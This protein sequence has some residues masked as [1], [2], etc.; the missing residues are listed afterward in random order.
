MSRLRPHRLKVRQAVVVLL[1]VLGLHAGATGEDKIAQELSISDLFKAAQFDRWAGE[2]SHQDIIW[3]TRTLIHGLSVHQRMVAHLE[4]DIPVSE[5]LKRAADETLLMLLQV[6]D[7]HGLRYRDYGLIDLKQNRQESHK[8][9]SESTWEAFALP[10]DY[11][12]SFLLY[13]KASGEHSFAQHTLHVAAVKHDDFEEIWQGTPKW[14]FWGALTEL[15][16]NIYRPDIHSRLHLVLATKNP[17]RVD[18]LADLTPSDLFH[19]SAR[20]YS[21]FLSVALP[22]LKDLSDIQVTNGTLN[23]SA[24]DL[25]Q[26]RVTFEQDKVS[27]LNWPVLK[28]VVAPESGPA[29]IDVRGLEAKQERPDFLRDEILR[30]LN[31][32][33]DG[34]SESEPAPSTSVKA[35][36]PFHVFI[37]VGSP[38]DFY[39]F[40]HFPSIDPAEAEN[41]VVYYLQYEVYGPSA[42][43]ALGS[44][45]K[46]LKPLQIH[47]FKVRSAES[48]REALEKILKD[49]GQM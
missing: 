19:G 3:K 13:D 14:E 7:D 34:D 27:S 37:V 18:V 24:L 47:T 31:P 4:I 38:M 5:L 1:F 8:G 42:T 46:M 25:R 36:A 21:R 39:A 40:R 32:A 6:E 12:I 15:R 23:V 20:F 33:N 11:K 22:L 10:G 41:C 35:A 29:M 2:S 49:A 30:R 45:R 9:T 26:R 44:V 28:S 43:G 17:V 16:D 48:V